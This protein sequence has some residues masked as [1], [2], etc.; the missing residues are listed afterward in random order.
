M[1]GDRAG[2]VALNRDALGV[3]NERFT[4]A[5]A[6]ELLGADRGRLGAVRRAGPQPRRP[7][8]RGRPRRGR[9]RV[10]HRLLLGLAGPAPAPG[11]S[12]WTSP[13][14]S[15]PPPGACSGRSARPSR[16]SR[17]TPSGSRWPAAGSTWWSASTAPPPGAT[18]SAGCPRRPGCSGPGADWCSSPTAC[19]PRSACPPEDGVADERLRPRPARGLP[20]A[21][22][23]AAASSTTPRTATGSGCCARSGFEVEALHEIY[24]PADAADHR[25]YE[26]VSAD[27]ARRGPA[28]SCGWPAP[29]PRRS[30]ERS[31]LDDH[32]DDHRPAP[33]GVVDPAA[34]DPADGLLQLVGV[35][36]ALAQQ[37]VQR[38]DDR[39]LDLVEGRRRPRRSRGRGSRGRWR[40]CR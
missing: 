36:D 27:W 23:R 19:S 14:S 34:D 6:D 33:V 10:R 22:V 20:G 12:P 3:V 17:R 24:A 1:T 2:E 31:G 29:G 39:L 4:D 13:A 30:S 15:W 16:S 21:L 37:R 38:V 18:R 28:R 7:R 25:F 5:A 32:R 9:A 11:W 8:R 40:P 35:V 26:I